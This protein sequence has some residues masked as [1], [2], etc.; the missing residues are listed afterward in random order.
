[1]KT[2]VFK[3]RSCALQQKNSRTLC[4]ILYVRLYTG[5][6][7]QLRL[8]RRRIPPLP[9]KNLRTSNRKPGIT[10]LTPCQIPS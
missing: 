6:A 1:M 3:P 8:L 7:P 4:G 2:T 5:N 9:S 10:F